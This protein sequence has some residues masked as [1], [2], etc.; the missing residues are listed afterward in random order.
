[1]SAAATAFYHRLEFRCRNESV[2]FSIHIR[3]NAEVFIVGVVVGCVMVSVVVVEYLFR[4]RAE[5][6]SSRN[7]DEVMAAVWTSRQ[8]YRRLDDGLNGFDI[9]ILDIRE[10]A[11]I[12]RAIDFC[13]PKPI[14]VDF[15]LIIVVTARA[16]RMIR[17]S[18]EYR[19][20]AS[21]VFEVSNIG[22]ERNHF[23][24]SVSRSHNLSRSSHKR[25]VS[26]SG[27]EFVNAVS[28]N[29]TSH[30]E[31]IMHQTR[32]FATI[33]SRIRVHDRAYR[34]INIGQ[35]AVLVYAFCYGRH[36]LCGCF[37]WGVSLLFHTSIL[38]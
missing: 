28:L 16:V 24:P 6:I 23:I 2:Q 27:S 32:A 33:Q 13:T 4:R 30:I 34:V 7:R 26:S 25:V 15:A 11:I 19:F 20:I 37:G 12:I 38:P 3:T 14:D 36:Q 8:P 18:K 35:A 29:A 5:N 9:A 22:R 31:R 10:Y 1:M 17:A 21:F